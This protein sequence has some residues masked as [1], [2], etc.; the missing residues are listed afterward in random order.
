MSGLSGASGPQGYGPRD[1]DEVVTG[2]AVALDLP[3]AGIGVRILAGLIDL[4]VMILASI[5]IGLVLVTGAA[6]GA[7]VAW[8]QVAVIVTIAL[9]LVGLPTAQETLT[10][11][12]TVGKWALGLRV[13]REDAGPITFQHAFVRAIVGVVEIYVASGLIAFLAAI[14]SARTKR[15]GDYAAGTYV[16]R[17]RA[18]VSLP[19]PPAMPPA[20]AGWASRADLGRMPP[21]L[22]LAIRRYLAARD[23]GPAR[24]QVGLRLCE[25][26]AA[27][28]AP[29]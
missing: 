9:T 16:V 18:R 25:R 19:P 27:L 5:G 17:D 7:D 13:V 8:A 2:E 4:I 28:V 1:V 26:T 21:G 6:A 23:R 29:P 22:T 11:G 15:L 14:L 3:A 20:L 10:R 12:R 24:D